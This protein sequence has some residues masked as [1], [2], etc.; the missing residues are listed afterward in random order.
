VPEGF[1]VG[2]TIEDI[3]TQARPVL[4]RLALVS[5]APTG[6]MDAM[7][8]THGTPE[9]RRPPGEAIPVAEHLA[10]RL[11][12][13]ISV[14]EAA[15]LLDEAR[16]ELSHALRRGMA[17]DATETSDELAER[18]IED[19]CGWP[20]ADVARA[21]RCLPSFV[22]RAREAVGRDP[23][24]GLTLPDADPMDAARVLAEAGRSTRTIERLTGIPRST[25][26]YRLGLR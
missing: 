5:S 22:R 10:H 20:V 24:T 17:Y 7:P 23:E 4:V 11:S 12:Q 16:A 2:Q 13:V 21:M 1:F 18:I 8:R 25:L 15:A 26:R 14:R 6:R 3:R 9:H 19:G